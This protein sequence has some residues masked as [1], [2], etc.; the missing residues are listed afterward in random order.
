VLA[1]QTFNM[2]V[3]GMCT[4]AETITIRSYYLTKT[5]V[6]VNVSLTKNKFN[7]KLYNYGLISQWC[8]CAD[9]SACVLDKNMSIC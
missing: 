6:S 9:R 3:R 4:T 7:N 5:L 8:L 2:I 1:S